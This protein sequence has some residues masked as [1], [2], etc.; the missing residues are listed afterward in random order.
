MAGA[1]A[2]GVGTY[3]TSRTT[4]RTATEVHQR[5]SR[6]EA[7]LAFL[8]AATSFEDAAHAFI[9]TFVSNRD[10]ADRPIDAAAAN[11]LLAQLRSEQRNLRH[12]LPAVLLA[13]P[14]ETAE[15][16]TEMRAQAHRIV[17]GAAEW[18]EKYLQAP[19]PKEVRNDEDGVSATA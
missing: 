4:S 16:A 9:N 15:F 3:L 6:R 18:T 17:D 8:A 7:Y 11:E 19:V 12:A 1:I 14:E 5:Q 2:T 13:G 10:P